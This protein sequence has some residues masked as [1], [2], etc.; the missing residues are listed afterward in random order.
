MGSVVFVFGGR[1]KDNN[2][3]NS[4][5]SFNFGGHAVLLLFMCVAN[6]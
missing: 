4:L 3:P 5:H 6:A 2:C 1:E